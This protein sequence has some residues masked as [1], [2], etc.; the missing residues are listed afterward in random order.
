M[1]EI[2]KS[3]DDM[4]ELLTS[5]LRT[6]SDVNDESAAQSFSWLQVVCFRFYTDQ[7]HRLS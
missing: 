7:N 2:L 5:H 4:V 6:G 3:D 1:V